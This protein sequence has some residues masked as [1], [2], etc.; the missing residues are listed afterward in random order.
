MKIG[1]DQKYQDSSE[2]S[3]PSF[4][5]SICWGSKV[6]PSAGKLSKS[7]DE[8]IS[9]M[10]KI[11]KKNLPQV[12]TKILHKKKFRNLFE[13]PVTL[14][15]ARSFPESESSL[16]LVLIRKGWELSSDDSSEKENRTS[17]K[18]RKRNG[19]AKTASLFPTSPDEELEDWLDHSAQNG[20]ADPFELILLL[21]I[22]FLYS[23]Q[24]KDS[25]F[26]KLWR[27]SLVASLKF[28][29]AEAELAAG[30]AAADQLLMVHGEIAWLSSQLFN[31]V[32]GA[33][34]L[35]KQAK[36]YLV[37]DLK[38]KTDTDG[39]PSADILSRADLWL[40]VLVRST[41]WSQLANRKLWNDAQVE[42]LSKL[43]KS[44]S[45]ICDL[46]GRIAM[47]ENHSE[48][49]LS[50][51]LTG[52]ALL[53]WKKKQPASKY[54]HSIENGSA[55]SSNNNQS[56]KRKQKK[57][58]FHEDKVPANQSDWASLGILRSSWE[59]Y[60]DWCCVTYSSAFPLIELFAEGH[61]IL[62]GAWEFE[63]KIDGKLASVDGDWSSSC[64]HSDRDADYMEL[65]LELNSGV[66]LNRQ[67]LIS[68]KD[69]FAILADNV[70]NANDLRIDYISRF[71]LS[72]GILVEADVPT[73]ECRLLDQK[74][75]CRAF[76]LGLP[77]DRVLSAA[78]NF[79][80]EKGKLELQQ[81]AQ[82][83]L[84][85][86]LVLDWNPNRSHGDRD[87]KKLTVCEDG[88]DLQTSLANAYRLRMSKKQLLM[89]HSLK[90]G[91]FPRS[92][93]G[94]HTLNETVIGMF[95]RAGEIDP[96][97][98]VEYDEDE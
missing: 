78:G 63:I 17:K 69:Q 13:I 19:Q 50:I 91:R 49:G 82:G 34:G 36:K 45:S 39:T 2:L 43:I 32:Q 64:W 5:K 98:L 3:D 21:E 61:P 95:D 27:T 65:E 30:N 31:A 56:K 7:D 12:E 67:I 74:L 33:S 84:Y 28:I 86:P 90:P 60:A 11:L 38:G 25:L 80:M 35:F 42:L 93:L 47:S 29:D 10:V 88:V 89:Y 53:G 15:S 59:K 22:L 8:T 24:M 73:R 55:L 57:T 66:H 71:P 46:Q 94:H 81:S 70:F 4:I 14:W 75:T 23:G 83:G 9:R 6:S 87:W 54:I 76:P 96:I 51:L 68:R 41:L 37:E 58:K 92:F 48:S 1:F 72:E 79:G 26:W 85:A 16:S 18:S 20:L 40:A 52:A 44:L 62:K 77:A 97:L